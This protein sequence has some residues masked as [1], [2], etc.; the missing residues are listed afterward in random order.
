M[1]RKFDI[2]ILLSDLRAIALA[3]LNTKLASIDAEKNDG[4]TLKQL[5]P[6]KVFFQDLDK[7]DAAAAP[8]FLYYGLDDPVTDAIGAHT[9]LQLSIYFIL[10][11]QDTAEN[12]TYMTRLLRYM[13]A[14]QEIFQENYATIQYVSRIQVSSL[15]PV[16]FTVE[17]TGTFKATGVKIKAVLA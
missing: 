10:V 15:S 16:S 11:L 2:E 6:D 14:M 12:F 9:A 17:G 3:N 1:A 5:D 8:L 13:R 7:S 4:I